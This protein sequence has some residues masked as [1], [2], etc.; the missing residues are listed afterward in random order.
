M[1]V[2]PAATPV[3]TPV[4]EPTVATVVV[5]LLHLPPK[6]V[7]LNVV[8]NPTQ[9]CDVPVMGPGPAKIVTLIAALG[10]SQPPIVCET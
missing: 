10:L 2:V 8:V 7:S 6:V 9:T 3:T 5:P 4:P 1:I